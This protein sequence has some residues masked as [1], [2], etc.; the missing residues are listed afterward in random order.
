MPLHGPAL[1]RS[2]FTWD[3][4][5]GQATLAFHTA[6]I[7]APPAAAIIA[8]EPGCPFQAWSLGELVRIQSMLKE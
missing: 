5:E 2:R 6:E 1:S 7:T 3:L 4:A 8:R